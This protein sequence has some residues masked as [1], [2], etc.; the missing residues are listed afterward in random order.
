[1][2]TPSIYIE[3]YKSNIGVFIKE[4]Y[5]LNYY[6]INGK[7]M[8]EGISRK[9]FRQFEFDDITSVQRVTQPTYVVKGYKLRVPELAT[10]KIPEY[11]PLSEL[12][13]TYDEDGDMVWNKYIDIQSLYVADQERVE[14]KLKDVDFSLTLLGNLVIEN[15]ESPV[16]MKVSLTGNS[17]MKQLSEVDLSSIAE[18]SQL[19]LMLTPEFQMHERPCTISSATMYKIVRS[20]IKTN[21]NPKVAEITSDYDFCFTVKKKI[22][23]KP[24]T[25]RT[26][27]KKQNGRSYAT[28]RFTTSKVTYKSEQIF[29]MTW[30]GYRGT[31]GYDGYTCIPAMKAANLKDLAEGLKHYLTCLMEEINKEVVECEHCKGM[32]AIVKSISNN[33]EKEFGE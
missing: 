25:T 27:Q 12:D 1:M 13:V 11:I 2:A 31:G 14:G 5:A 3:Y 6:T 23:I 10:D 19:E 17:N 30:A 7:L 8:S 29:E 16:N 9:G 28:P 4:N 24:Y 18:Y 33:L 26:E 21:I 20:W 15:I 32:G 22:A